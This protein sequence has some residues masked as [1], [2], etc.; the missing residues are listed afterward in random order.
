MHKIVQSG[1]FLGRL[2]VPVLKTGLPLIGKVL[3]PLAKSVLRS[4]G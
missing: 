3:Q 4:L 1:R 2:L